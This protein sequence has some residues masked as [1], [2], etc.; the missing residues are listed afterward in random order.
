MRSLALD[1]APVL[2]LAR[3]STAFGAISGVWFTVLWTWSLPSERST[4]AIT[5]SPLWLLLGGG[6]LAAGGLYGFGAGLNDLL[7]AHRDRV[8]RPSRPIPGGT[9]PAEAAVSVVAVSLLLS[10]LGATAFGTAA[11]LATLFLSAAI[12]VFNALGKFVPAIGMVLLSVIY[13]GHALVP[14]LWVSF[15]FP[16]WWVMTHAMVIGGLSHSLGRKSPMISRRAASFAFAGWTLCTAVMA[17]YA[18]KRLGGVFWPDWVPW[19][20]AL[21]PT[22]AAGILAIQIFRRWKSLGAGPKLG[23]KIT[24][25]GAFWPT[26]YG[27]GWLAGVGAWRAVIIMSLLAVSGTIAITILRE[28]YALSE[29]PVGYRL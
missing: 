26:L 6:V 12:L 13:A 24:R 1:L 21:W 20:A 11:V 3:V 5:G 2:R 7:D 10:V 8:L 23:E 17:Y 15:L 29:H 14:N 16:A 28:F 25:Y 9:L 18:W 4:E 19:T 22:A 27:V